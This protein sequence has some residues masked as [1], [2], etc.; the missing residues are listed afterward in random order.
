[1]SKKINR[2]AE[3][4]KRALS[5]P[6]VRE[7]FEEG[8]DWLKLAASVAALREQLGLT[9]TQLAKKIHT[10]QSVISRIENGDNVELKTLQEVA[11]A[12]NAKIKIELVHV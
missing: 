4:K 11:R 10:S 9:Q 8:L 2:Y 7:S 3:F 12:L 5:R 6:E 1:M